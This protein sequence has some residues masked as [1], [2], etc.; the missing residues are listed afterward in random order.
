MQFVKKC[1]F[2]LVIW[3]LVSLTF[4]IAYCDSKS[5]EQEI[6][7]K[8]IKYLAEDQSIPV[9]GDG[10]NSPDFSLIPKK[11]NE[12]ITIGKSF[13]KFRIIFIITF[14]VLMILLGV[15]IILNKLVSVRTIDLKKAN[16]RLNEE[17]DELEQLNDT[18]G[19]KNKELVGME[20]EL[21]QQFN[22]LLENEKKLTEIEKR[23]RG[24]VNALPD[25]VFSFDKK[26]IVI[27]YQSPREE[28]LQMP[29]NVYIGKTLKEVM[30]S[31]IAQRGEICIQKAFESGELQKIE[32]EVDINREREHFEIRFVKSSED[33]VIG[34]CRNVSA[35]KRYRQKIEYLS[36]R[37]QLTGLYNRRFFEEELKRLDVK[38]N[39]PLGII[40][41]DVNG[42]KLVNDSF[43]HEVG[44][45]LLKRV[46]KVITS[47]CK[48]EEVICRI[49][50]D[51]FV[52]LIPKISSKEIEKVI[53]MIK[54]NVE[55]EKIDSIELSISFGWELKYSLD[56]DVHEIF[57]CA[58][59]Y[60][61]KN[62]L[63][64]GPSMR[65]KTISAI[66]HTLNEKNVREE[67]HS[68][69]VSELSKRLAKKL[70]FTDRMVEEIK[71]T[72]LLHD[73]GKIAINE[74]ILNKIGHLNGE[75][76]QEIKRH[77]E[78][79]YR[80]LHSANDMVEISEYVLYHHEKWN[81]TGYPKGI[82]G[83]AIPIQSRIISIADT[84]DAIT[85]NRTYRNKN[86]KEE[87]LKE[88]KRC[89]GTQFDPN[90]VNA[91]IELILEEGE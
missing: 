31:K 74:E 90:L 85:S 34:I 57:R 8:E 24:I 41:A 47:T 59:N 20:E 35:D 2:L 51:E 14:L 19:L 83:D 50:G 72:G 63:F 6:Q 75:E 11:R 84:Y 67:Q 73:I 55:K 33:E 21:R 13:Y 38:E 36:Y 43:G 16:L 1:F 69:R 39:F 56:E 28:E 27:D 87:A 40:M 32:Y 58:E 60:M 62:K 81:G 45:E 65:S 54:N 5:T 44:D 22:Q 82:A 68:Q 17:Q 53:S 9:M 12:G 77:P 48:S 15:A 7:P 26:C 42:L 3:T 79:G 30:P 86:S 89:K 37:D 49:G 88:L 29:K 23:N 76:L 18:L 78:I 91:F 61:Y 71:T 10:T 80:I 64:E 46:S 4:V 66:V 25:M 52:I 70:G